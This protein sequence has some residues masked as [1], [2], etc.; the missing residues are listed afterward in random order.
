V[1]LFL[2]DTRKVKWEMKKGKNNAN[3]KGK[4]KNRDFMK[5][6][7]NFNKTGI[8]CASVLVVIIA[9]CL[10]LSYFVFTGHL[11]LSEGFN[12]VAMS[13][14]AI[15]VSYILFIGRKTVHSFGKI[16]VPIFI[17]GS[18]I[19]SANMGYSAVLLFLDKPL[20]D[21]KDLLIAQ[22][23]PESVTFENDSKGNAGTYYVDIITINGKNIKVFH[24]S[25]TETEF[26]KKL[27]KKE[28]KIKYLPLS[29][30]A[31]SVEA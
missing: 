11:V 30:Y 26:N 19:V 24:L 12:L 27:Y 1:L 25:I 13:A 10:W 8:L 20:Y 23:I 18:L 9:V 16:F 17:T 21:R 29:K 15:I 2:P 22:G 5:F 3:L 4:G 28:L 7:G 14:S 31:V 6:A